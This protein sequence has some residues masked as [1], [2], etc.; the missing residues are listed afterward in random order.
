MSAIQG[1]E[2]VI[3]QLQATAMSA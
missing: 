2:G 3:S 1:I